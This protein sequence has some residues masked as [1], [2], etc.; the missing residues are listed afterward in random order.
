MS[1]GNKKSTTSLSYGLLVTF[2]AMTIAGCGGGG[3]GSSGGPEGGGPGGSAPTPAPSPAPAPATA[4]PSIATPPAAATVV[5]GATAQ[6]KV[7]AAGDAPLTYLWRRN[8]ADLADGAGITGA[9]TATISVTAPYSYNTSQISVR[10]SNAAG[11]V[12][13]DNALLTVTPIAPTITALPANT[14]AN[15]GLAVMISATVTGGTAPVTYQWKRDGKVMPGETR[16]YIGIGYADLRDNASVFVLD[17][18]NPAG[19][20][21]SQTMLTVVP[22]GT[23]TAFGVDTTDD[24]IDADL[25][26]GVCLTSA[27]NCSLRAAVMQADALDG[28]LTAISV[29]AGIYKL[30]REPAGILNGSNGNLN[31]TAPIHPD[32]K[33]YINGAG[34]ARTIIDGNQLDNVLEV[35]PGRVVTLAGLTLR[36]GRTSGEDL[37]G[38]IANLGGSLTV[39]DC[40]I[41]HGITQDSGG[42]IYSSGE[43]YVARSTIQSN[44]AESGGG[45]FLWGK[46]RVLESTING[47]K[48]VN[49]GGIYNQ[50]IAYLVNSTVSSNTADTDGGGIYAAVSFPF[51]TVTTAIYSTSIIGNDA[52]HDRDQLGG[53]GGG[54]FNAVNSRFIAVNA[55]LVRNTLLDS[56]QYDDC[57][58][59][60]E[61]HGFNLL[62]APDGCT[63]SGDGSWKRVSIDAV[64]PALKDNGGPTFTHATFDG[65]E[66]PH[67]YGLPACIDENGI[68]LNE[69]QRGA[70]R[71]DRCDIGAYEFGAVAP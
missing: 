69:D 55:L 7:T 22:A 9:T 13:S 5:D 42:G 12:V 58:G 66:T 24:L 53:N 17:I 51:M 33:I 40:V 71:G 45:L 64:D 65:P 61:L 4:A 21:S 38:I 29:P 39:L 1:T 28:F 32:D 35:D 63:F 23:S 25:N 15:S 41:E 67:D 52:D 14:I 36:N 70:P 31:L 50:Q 57:S 48:A 11:F 44:S 2:A 27:N 43:L 54:V 46:A 26:D 16:T 10:V 37:G 68:P 47:N 19:T 30:T 8:G 62:G 60:L 34:A 59:K 6:F 49:G 18:T 20:F 3:G 56:P